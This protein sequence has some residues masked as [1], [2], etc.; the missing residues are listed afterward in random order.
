M[1]ETDKRR[2]ILLLHEEGMGARQIAKRLSVSRN[3]VRSIIAA[4]GAVPQVMRADK[5]WIDEELLRQL[6]QE[7]GGFVQRVHE[8]LIEEKN[9]LV[10]CCPN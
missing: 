3:T 2:A 4:R 6:Y 10:H 9:I 7:C 8:K 5:L 1:L